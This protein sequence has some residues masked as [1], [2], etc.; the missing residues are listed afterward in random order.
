MYGGSCVVKSLKQ[1]VV[2]HKTKKKRIFK[3][4]LEFTVVGVFP[5]VT[6]APTAGFPTQICISSRPVCLAAF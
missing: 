5:R 1:K 4:S 2:S 6:R 3:R